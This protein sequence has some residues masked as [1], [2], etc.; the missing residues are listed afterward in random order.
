MVSSDGDIFHVTGLLWG[1]ATGHQWIPLTKASDVE[2]W[3]LLWSVPEQIVEQTIEKPVIWDSNENLDFT[4]TTYH[5]SSLV[6]NI[7]K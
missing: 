4:D 3:C 2:L 1:E 7:V 6:Y 5:M